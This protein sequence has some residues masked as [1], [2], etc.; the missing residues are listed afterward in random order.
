MLAHVLRTPAWQGL[1]VRLCAVVMQGNFIRKR[2]SRDVTISSL[3]VRH[4]GPPCLHEQGA[5]WKGLKLCL[6]QQMCFLLC[7]DSLLRH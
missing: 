4:P 5:P 3:A 2:V 1:L 7:E 6:P